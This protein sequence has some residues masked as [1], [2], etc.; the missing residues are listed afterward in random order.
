MI[1]GQL[2]S[3]RLGLEQALER[4][5]AGVRH[6]KHCHQALR[7]AERKIELL[8]GIHENGVAVT[9]PF[10]D[11]AVSL[12]EKHAARSRRRTL[13]PENP[14]RTGSLLDEDPTA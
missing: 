6:L 13:P 4:Y 5:E 7:Q 3:G 14:P 10:D 8:V 11:D 2:E 9:R 12:E 1:V